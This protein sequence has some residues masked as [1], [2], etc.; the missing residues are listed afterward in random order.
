MSFI[1]DEQLWFLAMLLTVPRI[2]GAFLAMPFLGVT[3][4]PGLARNALVIIISAFA[5]P[6][7]LG[8][9][10]Q[11]PMELGTIAVLMLKEM[12]LGFIFGYMVSIPFWAVS[13]AGF[14][15]DLQRGVLSA[16]M[17]SNVLGD[18]SS[19]LGDLFV[20]LSVVLLFTTGGFL[21]LIEVLVSSYQIWPVH[22]FMPDF[23]VDVVGII[24]KQFALLFYMAALIAGPIVATMFIVELGSALISRYVPQLNIF[25][26]LM[27]IK[28]GVAIFLLIFYIQFIS[29]YMRDAFLKFGDILGMLD[30]I[31]K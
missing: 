18:Q 27:P 17:F 26:L 28:S 10:D 30:G 3:I 13:S 2:L 24:L 6:A 19:P 8:Y 12:A 7:T 11:V 4:L 20:K 23:S 14:I 5:A 16:Q 1:G 31:L 15:I 25:L 9:I 22:S 29:K 21:L